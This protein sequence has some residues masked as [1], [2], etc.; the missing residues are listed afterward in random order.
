MVYVRK[1][2]PAAELGNSIRTI[3]FSVLKIVRTLL[4]PA[5]GFK[6]YWL[7]STLC[8][9]YLCPI[10]G[11]CVHRGINTG[12]RLVIFS[13]EFNGRGGGP[14]FYNFLSFSSKM[15]LLRYLGLDSSCLIEQSNELTNYRSETTQ[16]MK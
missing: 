8:Q 14:P 7:T 3:I 4:P 16:M 12:G 5:P 9:P 6:M 13:P 1:S 10:S 2:C 11:V 15:S